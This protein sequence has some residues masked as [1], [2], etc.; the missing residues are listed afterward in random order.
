MKEKK[1]SKTQHRSGASKVGQSQVDWDTK[2]EV[3]SDW[4][5]QGDG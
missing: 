4:R 1:K 3:T 5:N 2:S